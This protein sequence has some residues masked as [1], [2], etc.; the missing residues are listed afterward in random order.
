MAVRARFLQLAG[1]GKTVRAGRRVGGVGV[2]EFVLPETWSEGEEE[3]ER[4]DVAKNERASERDR[5]RGASKRI[6]ISFV[7]NCITFWA[8][9]RHL[10]A[11]HCASLSLFPYLS[12]S[13][14]F[15]RSLSLSNERELVNTH[16]H[17]AQRRQ[18]RPQT[19][20][21]RARERERETKPFI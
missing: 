17:I 1:P 6:W 7:F 15:Y 19:L 16:K 12:P 4:S 2:G 18:T 13:V 11:C 9:P 20:Y 10:C 14:S 3:E 5:E 21:N 8:R